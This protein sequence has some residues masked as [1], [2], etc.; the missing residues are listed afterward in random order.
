MISRLE[1]P[2][3]NDTYIFIL[4]FRRQVHNKQIR[5][6]SFSYQTNIHTYI[7]LLQRICLLAN[8]REHVRKLR[9]LQN[10]VMNKFQKVIEKLIS[11]L[12]KI[13]RHERVHRRPNLMVSSMTVN[14]Q[15]E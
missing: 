11:I 2:F 1:C 13:Y 5:K 14:Q 3:Y 15:L 10:N 6:Y 9:Y 4:Y 7:L 12:L 8:V